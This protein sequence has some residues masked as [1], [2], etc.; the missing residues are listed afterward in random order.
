MC[1]CRILIKITYLVNYPQLENL[2]NSSLKF[3]WNIFRKKKATNAV[4]I[5][6][7]LSLTISWTSDKQSV[8]TNAEIA[9][10]SEEKR[11]WFGT[12]G[13]T[14]RSS[15][16]S[17]NYCWISEHKRPDGHKYMVLFRW[18]WMLLHRF[19]EKKVGHYYFCDSCGRSGPIFI[20]F[21]TVKFRKVHAQEAQVKT[22][23]SPPICCRTP[24]CV[25]PVCRVSWST[26]C[27]V[28][29]AEQRDI[30]T[31]YGGDKVRQDTQQPHLCRMVADTQIRRRGRR[32]LCLKTSHDVVDD[33][34]FTRRLWRWTPSS[35]LALTVV[36]HLAVVERRFL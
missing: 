17:C 20:I 1:V 23:T 4:F 36:L 25:W 7:P 26:S 21:F 3:K 24:C 33:Y 6:D 5:P 2:R 19:S 32:S 10:L 22:T 13:R 9:S 16:K 29:Q 31:I 14:D 28:E 8:A 35:T 12:F 27:Y 30:L 11:R 34:S 15:R 18:Y